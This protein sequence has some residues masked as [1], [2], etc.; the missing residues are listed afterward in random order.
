[1]LLSVMLTS[2]AKLLNASEFEVF[3]F[4]MFVS[5]ASVDLLNDFFFFLSLSVLCA[6]NL[7]KKDFFRKYTSFHLLFHNPLVYLKLHHK[8]YI[9]LFIGP[10][11]SKQK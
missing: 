4:S 9:F 8:M 2:A 5:G 1:M 11:P 10:R 3:F 6:K 7:A